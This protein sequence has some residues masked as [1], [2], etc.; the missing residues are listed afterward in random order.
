MCECMGLWH[1]LGNYMIPE[2]LIELLENMYDKSSSAVR[3]VGELTGWFR[4]TVG[5]RQS[6]GLTP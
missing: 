3:V 6:C 4:V 5:V 1:V 2:E